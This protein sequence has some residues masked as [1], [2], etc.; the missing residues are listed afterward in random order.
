MPGKLFRYEILLFGILCLAVV[1]PR[2][3]VMAHILKFAGQNGVEGLELEER[4]RLLTHLRH[5]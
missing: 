4:Q 1:R 2:V 5:L 3:S